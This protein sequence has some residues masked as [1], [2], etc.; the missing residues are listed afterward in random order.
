MTA[1]KFMASL[2]GRR[3]I[4]ARY[5]PDSLAAPEMGISVNLISFISC[6]PFSLLF[7]AM[8]SQKYGMILEIH[9]M[10]LEKYGILLQNHGM[11]FQKHGTVLEN[12][13][14]I[15]PKDPSPCQPHPADKIPT[16]RKVFV[17][18]RHLIS[19]LSYLH[20]A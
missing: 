2:P 4:F 3:S 12:H 9:G 6:L 15:I 18:V 8:I 14:I 5:P 20:I 19:A 17:G 11:F 13:G 7:Y 10:I 1:S 16:L